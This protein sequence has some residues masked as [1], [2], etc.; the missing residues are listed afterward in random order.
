M[1]AAH[2][3]VAT[4]YVVKYVGRTPR[5][6]KNR[7]SRLTSRMF[8]TVIPDRAASCKQMREAIRG[9]DVKGAEQESWLKQMCD[10]LSASYQ[11]G[12]AESLARLAQK[13][14][15]ILYRLRGS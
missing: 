11:A 9:A 1:S 13:R 6:S 2:G 5:P 4:W 15:Q 8:S 3:C 7:C 10:N 12:H 14:D